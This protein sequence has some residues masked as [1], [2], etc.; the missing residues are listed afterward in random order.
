MSKGQIATGTVTGT[1]AALNVELGFAPK[2][3]ILINETDPGMF[4]WSD[5]MADAEMAKLTD[6]PALTFPTANGISAYSGTAATEGAGFTIG[7]DADMNAA[8]DVIHY[9]A[10][11]AMG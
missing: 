2:F 5:Q 9:V 3:I 11:G 10:F 1:G 7:A 4:M 8:S 6:A